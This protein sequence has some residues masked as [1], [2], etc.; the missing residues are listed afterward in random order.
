MEPMGLTGEQREFAMAVR[1][2]CRKECGTR[3]QRDALTDHGAEQHNQGVIEKLASL[4]YLGVSIP[5]EY[6]GSGGGLTEQVILFEELWR[7]LAPVHGAGSSHTVAG[8]YKRYATEEQKS[9]VLGAICS[10]QVMSISIS[11]PGAGSDAAAISCKA[12][13]V[14]GGWRLTGQKTWC[15]DAQ[16]ATAIL[17]L[18]RT[19]HGV[20]PH[21]GM[22][23]QPQ[24]ADRALHPRHRLDDLFDEQLEPVLVL[25]R[26]LELDHD[27]GVG[28]PCVLAVDGDNYLSHAVTG[29]IDDIDS[30]RLDHRIAPQVVTILRSPPVTVVARHMT[31]RL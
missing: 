20:R 22:P 26:L 15:S 25:R 6:G 16:F 8:I 5:E 18:V 7:G 9:A 27:R 23:P 21:D 31:W 19:S 12:E 4:G 2:F 24:H 17:V 29:H 1:E 3:E 28:K 14:D 11:E 13:K 10:G 30:E